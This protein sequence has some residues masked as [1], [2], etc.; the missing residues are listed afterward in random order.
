MSEFHTKS[1]HEEGRLTS[2]H[3]TE[4]ATANQYRLVDGI[5]SWI[6]MSG[7]HGIVRGIEVELFGLSQA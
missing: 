5:E 3:R 1:C 4:M 2:L 7:L 6:A